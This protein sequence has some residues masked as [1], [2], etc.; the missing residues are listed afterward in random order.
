MPIVGQ[1]ENPG[2]GFGLFDAVHVA[3]A[4][5]TRMSPSA[6]SHPRPA[7]VLSNPNGPGNSRKRKGNRTYSAAADDNDNEDEMSESSPSG[8]SPKRIRTNTKTNNARWACHY[9]KLNPVKYRS[10]L[11]RRLSAPR[12][13]KEHLLRHHLQAVH[14]PTCQQLF[15]DCGSR[16]AHITQ[17]QCNIVEPSAEF[18]Q[19]ISED[20]ERKLRNLKGGDDGCGTWFKIWVILFPKAP[21]PASP[22][23]TDADWDKPSNINL[24]QRAEPVMREGLRNVGGLDV[25]QIMRIVLGALNQQLSQTNLPTETTEQPLVTGDLSNAY[26]PSLATTQRSLQ[27]SRFAAGVPPVTPSSGAAATP[28]INPNL[29]PPPPPSQPSASVTMDTLLQVDSNSAASMWPSTP[30][31]EDFQ[32]ES[33]A[34]N[35]SYVVPQPG[36][37]PASA[38]I[39]FSDFGQGFLQGAP[40]ANFGYGANGVLV[41]WP[42]PLDVATYFGPAPRGWMPQ[43]TIPSTWPT[44]PTGYNA[45]Q[46]FNQHPPQNPWSGTASN[47]PQQRH[48]QGQGVQRNQTRRP[49]TTSNP[50][51]AGSGTGNQL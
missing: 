17:Q 32:L 23:V 24:I 41:P 43:G 2:F 22:L 19:R 5:R 48:P 14:C 45:Q 39:R 51:P 28:H 36:Q 7:L 18:K 13:V 34:A 20:Q 46:M 27:G 12:Y 40:N 35:D 33:S 38:S 8:P 50:H 30:G 25:E 37:S 44:T 3:L 6:G 42:S 10:C 21:K 9:F 49:A 26:A 47:T 1:R 29:P 4:F 31:L 16:D 15:K 11:E